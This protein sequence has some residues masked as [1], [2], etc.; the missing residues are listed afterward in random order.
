MSNNDMSHR[1]IAI[2][3]RGYRALVGGLRALY[4]PNEAT[5][6]AP[7]LTKIDS[8]ET[9]FILTLHHRL[10][11]RSALH[12]QSVSNAPPTLPIPCST[13][14]RISLEQIPSTA[15]AQSILAPQTVDHRSHLT[16]SGFVE[17]S[18]VRAE[19]SFESR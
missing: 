9:C 13:A 11:V 3:D 19:R 5:T 10:E 6:V 1:E 15:L 2:N 18:T 8:Q 14:P 4:T 17:L 12:C 16:S 7:T